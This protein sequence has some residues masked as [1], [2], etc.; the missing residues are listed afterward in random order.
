M[1]D[2]K[3]GFES[4]LEELERR[5]RTLESGEV[6]LDEALQLFEEGVAL[7][8]ACHEYLQEAETRVAALTDEAGVPSETPLSEPE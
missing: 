3:A 4:S 1:S 7:A 5:V 2:Q 8:R 6:S